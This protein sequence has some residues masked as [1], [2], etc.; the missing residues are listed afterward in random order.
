MIPPVLDPKTLSPGEREAFQRLRDDPAT[1]SW[2]VLH[3]LDIPN[4]RRRLSGEIDFVV[5]VPH[6]G[7]LCLEV[8]A[9]RKVAR[10]DGMWFLGG[11]DPDPRGPFKQASEGMH[12]LRTRL[13]TRRP[14][15]SNVMFWSAV[16]F[17]FVRFTDVSEEWHPWQVIDADDWA[18]APLSEAISRVL[19]SARTFLSESGKASWF[20]EADMTPTPEQCDL[21]VR[22]LRPDFEF[23]ESP[24]SRRRARIEELRHY[25]EEQSQALDAMQE[26]DR[27]IFEGPAGTGK[28]LL[29][30]E[31]ARRESLAGNRVLFLCFN[32]LLAAWIR[33]EVSALEGVTSSTFHSY[34]LGLASVTPPHDAVSA[35]WED[36]LPSLATDALLERSQ[37]DGPAFDVLIVDEAQDVM[38]GPYLDCLDLSVAGGLAAGR[39]R[40]FSDFARQSIFG[41]KPI[42]LDEFLARL[43]GRATKY[44]LTMNCRN[45]PRIASYVSVLARLDPTYSRVLRPDDGVQPELVFYKD[46]E[47]Q[48]QALV[49]VL[50]K[51]YTDG[52]RGEDIV[53][54]STISNGCATE[55]SEPPWADR[56][57]PYGTK[58]GYIGCSTVHSFKGLEAPVVVFT[59]V[60]YFDSPEAENV[61]YVGLTRAVDRLVIL[62][63]ENVKREIVAAA[64]NA[65]TSG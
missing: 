49:D 23:F 41:S 58:G 65:G 1:D 18:A 6:K 64:M 13:V 28:T 37:K 15:V 63:S 61:F 19:D 27:V 40:F 29:A 25:T 3:S 44:L 26:V 38:Q 24:A 35:F 46:P 45:T 62:V 42:G 52:Y 33:Q 2:T 60:S 8:K 55:V 10:R 57:K 16:L 53:I 56:L 12:S 4:H 21:V 51:L 14:A 7:V 48:R 39:W 17:P 50:Q 22:S 36:E 31:T 59:D 11:G 54:L 32:K 20:R 30:V 9:H 47:D 5:L 34:L 43:E